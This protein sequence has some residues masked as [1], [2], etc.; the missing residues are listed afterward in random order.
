MFLLENPPMKLTHKVAFYELALDPFAITSFLKCR[1][2]T[3]LLAQMARKRETPSASIGWA[4]RLRS[5]QRTNTYITIH[6]AI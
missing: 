6:D 3:P 5:V 2:R 4:E 1:D